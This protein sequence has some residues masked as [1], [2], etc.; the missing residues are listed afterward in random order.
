MK[1]LHDS[2]Y[3]FLF[4]SPELVR[5]LIMGFITKQMIYRRLKLCWV[6]D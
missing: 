5:D 2:S 1:K 3:K 4:S 6:I